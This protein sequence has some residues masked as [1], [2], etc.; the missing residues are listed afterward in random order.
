MRHIRSFA[1]ILM[2]IMFMT[3]TSCGGGGGS[4]GDESGEAEDKQQSGADQIEAITAEQARDALYAAYAGIGYNSSSDATDDEPLYE[5]MV[6]DL[7]LLASDLAVQVLAADDNL[8]AFM[9]LLMGGGSRTFTYQDSGV[10]VTLT[11]QYNMLTG[12]FS[13]D[14]SIDFDEEGYSYNTVTYAGTTSGVELTAELNGIIKIDLM[15]NTVTPETVNVAI[16]TNNDLTA[17]HPDRSVHYKGWSIS[18]DITDDLKNYNI[19]PA[20][21]AMIINAPATDER[22]YT[23][24]GSYDINDGTTHS[25]VFDMTYGQLTLGSGVYVALKGSLS[26]PG[27]E[28]K[29][30]KVSSSGLGILSGDDSINTAKSIC[31]TD[32]GLWTSGTVTINAAEDSYALSFSSDGS[33]TLSPGDEKVDDWQTAL[34]PF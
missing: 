16:T 8:N 19:A 24:K 13:A 14:V 26:L 10:D 9:A 18:Y 33:V 2:L 28:G 23:L 21:I 25:Y 4:G 31:R 3:L 15:N 27:F 17:A 6:A 32:A 22:L 12:R 7:N 11:V 34:A 29:V 1:M 20:L 30:V 5:I